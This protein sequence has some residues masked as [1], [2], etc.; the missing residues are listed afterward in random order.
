M[1]G[2]REQDDRQRREAHQQDQRQHGRFASEDVIQRIERKHEEGDD[3]EAG[4]QAGEIRCLD[5]ILGQDVGNGRAL[6]GRKVLIHERDDA[7]EGED[8]D[9]VVPAAQEAG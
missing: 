2:R 6:D 9:L 4:F 7:H 1:H 8:V 5:L 3:Q